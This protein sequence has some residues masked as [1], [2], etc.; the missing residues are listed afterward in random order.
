MPCVHMRWHM[1]AHAHVHTETHRRG[2]SFSSVQKT[3]IRYMETQR[4]MFDLASY[5]EKLCSSSSLESD[6]FDDDSLGLLI[7]VVS[8]LNRSMVKSMVK[9][10]SEA[11]DSLSCSPSAALAARRRS[12][13]GGSPHSQCGMRTVNNRTTISTTLTVWRRTL[14]PSRENR[15][16]V[17]NSD[18]T[19]LTTPRMIPATRKLESTMETLT[20]RP[21]Y[22]RCLAISLLAN[23][24]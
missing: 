7:A 12:G 14:K 18:S 10:S 17:K 9:S 6:G 3:Q 8:T 1:H 22:A 20:T 24:W 15:T 19:T 11:S 16:M 21:R 5:G 4:Y 13:G 2:C 23:S